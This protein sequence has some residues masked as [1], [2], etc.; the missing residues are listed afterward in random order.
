QK[1]ESEQIIASKPLERSEQGTNTTEDPPECEIQKGSEAVEAQLRNTKNIYPD[2]G[3][4]PF[5]IL[6]DCVECIRRVEVCNMESKIDELREGY[7]NCDKRQL[8]MRTKDLFKNEVR[9]DLCFGRSMS[10]A[11]HTI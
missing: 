5:G 8:S 4:D 3:V 6:R 2:E 10:N 11:T 9:C 7:K 1:M